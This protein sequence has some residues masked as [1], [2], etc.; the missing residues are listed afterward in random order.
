ML[1]TEHTLG[2]LYIL[3]HYKIANGIVLKNNEKTVSKMPVKIRYIII[4]LTLISLLRI[5]SPTLN[6]T[7]RTLISFV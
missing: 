6:P 3:Y 4:S 7:N 2:F 5:S 1:I